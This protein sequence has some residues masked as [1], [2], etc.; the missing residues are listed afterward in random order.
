MAYLMI[1]MTMTL[2]DIEGHFYCLK[3]FNQTYLGNFGL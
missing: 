1:P 3:S 2:G